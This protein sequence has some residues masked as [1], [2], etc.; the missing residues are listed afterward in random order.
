MVETRDSEKWQR[1]VHISCIIHSPFITFPIRIWSF[2]AAQT[3]RTTVWPVHESETGEERDEPFVSPEEY[4]H[5]VDK[6]RENIQIF[7]LRNHNYRGNLSLPLTFLSRPGGD[8]ASVTAARGRLKRKTG[9]EEKTHSF[10]QEAKLFSRS[11]NRHWNVG[12][13][14][15]RRSGGEPAIDKPTGADT[16]STLLVGLSRAKKTE[17]W[18]ARASFSHLHTSFRHVHFFCQLQTGIGKSQRGSHD[19]Q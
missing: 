15:I 19:S 10:I 8:G 11:R 16:R 6:M 5:R 2:P 3:S 13:L 12:V 1:N 9:N 14:T 7:V 17:I 18:A 4:Y